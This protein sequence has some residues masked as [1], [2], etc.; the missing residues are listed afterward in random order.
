MTWRRF[1]TGVFLCLLM[2]SSAFAWSNNITH[3]TLTNWAAD[4]LV[5]KNASYTYLN[6]HTH[7]NI[8]T[9]P[10]LTFLDE[11]SVK[12]DYGAGP[13]WSQAIWGDQQDSEVPL[14]SWWNHGYR[15]KDGESWDGIPDYS[16]AY[17]YSDDVWYDVTHQ[18]NK[19]FQMGRLCHLIEDMGAVPHAN[20]DVHVDGDDLE[21]WTEN[22][23]QTV[24][25]SAVQVRKPSTDGLTAQAGLPHPNLTSNTYGDYLR[26][27]A[28]RTYYMTTYWAGNL[29]EDEGNK[30]PDSELKRMFP[31]ISADTGYDVVLDGLDYTGQ[32]L[33]YNDGG[34]FGNDFYFASRGAVIVGYNWIGYGVGNNQDWWESPTDAGYYYLENIDG[35]YGTSNP[36]AGGYS[37]TPAVFKVNSFTRITASTNLNTALAANSTPMCRLY[38]ERVFPMVVEWVAGFI[39][40]TIPPDADADGIADSVDNCPYT[41]NSDQANAD[42]DAKGD[43]CEVC[44]NDPNKFDPGTC[45]CGVADTDTDHDGTPDCIDSC[46][47]DPNKIVPGTCGCGVADTD[48]DH[49]GTPD[50]VDSCPNDPA[51]IVPGTCGC[52]VADADAD[53]DGVL[54]CLDNCPATFN[55]GQEDMDH[56]GVGDVC[57][58]LPS[59]EGT[60]DWAVETSNTSDDLAGMWAASGPE[61]FACGA[62]GRILH[63]NGSAWAPMT[64]NTT[65]DL[66]AVWGV[67]ST[68]VFAVG[69]GGRILHYNGAW[70]AMTSN[71]TDNLK[72]MHGTSA[73]DVFAV[74]AGGRIQHYNGTWTQMTSNTVADLNAVYAAAANNAFAVGAGGVVMHY[75]GT[76][77]SS[78]AGYTTTTLNGV[79]GS[80]ASDV[81]VVGDRG[82]VAHYDGS[83]WT[84]L[85]RG[86][87]RAALYGVC[88][89]EGEV[90][91]V[92]QV[93]WALRYDG[94]VW[95]A[96]V[97]GTDKDLYAVAAASS[98]GNI[99]VFAGGA[100]GTVLSYAIPTAPCFI[101]TLLGW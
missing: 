99:N 74:G 80:S 95:T 97:S 101:G 88:G 30:Q 72:G 79:W 38:C 64:S 6:D 89:M 66:N 2:Q 63:Y 17:I 49:D 84:I 36:A 11:G 47:N 65:D 52:G 56:N 32:G 26:N 13:D 92:G 96:M 58:V 42:G 59:P 94:S 70:S 57:D 8:A 68:D 4:F 44:D 83:T 15:P 37:I 12:E 21:T 90:Y 27:V 100:E 76:A 54:D 48:T 40:N 7:F 51:K 23:V 33:Q 22:F 50:C 39:A 41:A 25:W 20:A 29:V 73:T 87:T 19:Y 45:G 34:W 75:D 16:N 35:D 3:P 62:G 10:Q 82:S 9:D 78:M 85:A 81:Y 91:A 98:P 71:T 18:A 5:Q 1:L 61:A 24:S 31:Y 77:W 67:S 60:P 28:W 55:P 69:A 86:I 93:G 14:L 53:G 46:P 43:A